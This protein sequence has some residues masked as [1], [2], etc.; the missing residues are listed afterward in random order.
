MIPWCSSMH[1]LACLIKCALPRL[2][3]SVPLERFLSPWSSDFVDGGPLVESSLAHPFSSVRFSARKD[4]RVSLVCLLGRMSSLLFPSLPSL[5]DGKT[6]M[7][8]TYTAFLLCVCF[9]DQ[10]T[11]T[12]LFLIL[13]LGMELLNRL[14]HRLHQ[15]PLFFP[16]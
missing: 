1:P 7:S 10:V 4:N 13:L 3:P 11:S 6:P 15:L 14:L 9:W 8:S 16:P 5:F 2:P 12:R